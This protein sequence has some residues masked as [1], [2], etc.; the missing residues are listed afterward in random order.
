M[1]VRERIVEEFFDRLIDESGNPEPWK[2]NV[3]AAFQRAVRFMLEQYCERPE[4]FAQYWGAKVAGEL[5]ES[6]FG[7]GQKARVFMAEL[8]AFQTDSNKS[9]FVAD[10]EESHSIKDKPVDLPN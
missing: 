5:I 10:R 8:A 9:L 6:L 7:K 1:Y 3:A 2:P 4:E